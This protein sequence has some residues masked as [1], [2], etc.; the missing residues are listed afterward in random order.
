MTK[1]EA[2]DLIDLMVERAA[3]LRGAGIR[4]VNL[5]GVSFTLAAP[6][7]APDDLDGNQD[8]EVP[9]DALHDP[10]TRGVPGPGAPKALPKRSRPL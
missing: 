8:E 10:W 9:T 5:G 7:H 6:D 4:S 2:S 3:D 1:Q